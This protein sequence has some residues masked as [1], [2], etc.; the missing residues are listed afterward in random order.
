MDPWYGLHS[1]RKH[2]REGVLGE[3]QRRDLVRQ[4][5]ANYSLRPERTKANFDRRKQESLP[6]G[7]QGSRSTGLRLAERSTGT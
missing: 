3:A 2:Y 5:K 1:W 7:E 4:A 6:R